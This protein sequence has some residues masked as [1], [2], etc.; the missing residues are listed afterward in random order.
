MSPRVARSHCVP[1]AS[2]GP[3]TP[4]G[5]ATTSRA[6]GRLTVHQGVAGDNVVLAP[7]RGAPL[8]PSLGIQPGEVV[9]RPA[10]TLE[11]M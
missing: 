1:T 5:P 2:N 6:A 9:V 8:S 3:N 4:V 7:R 11:P 10:A